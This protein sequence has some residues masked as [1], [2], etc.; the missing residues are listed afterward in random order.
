V[1]PGCAHSVVRVEA[2]D[3]DG[4]PALR[5]FY[6]F[7]D[8]VD[9]KSITAGHTV[10]TPGLPVQTALRSGGGPVSFSPQR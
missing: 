10:F 3:I 2:I 9:C 4:G 7:A 6:S 1:K 5:R 8:V